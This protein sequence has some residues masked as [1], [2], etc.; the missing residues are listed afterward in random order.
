MPAKRRTTMP[1]QLKAAFLFDMGRAQKIAA[2]ADAATNALTA[3]GFEPESPIL[4]AVFESI[5]LALDMIADKYDIDRGAVSR[6]AFDN[7]FGAVGRECKHVDVPDGLLPITSPEDF[8][9]SE[10]NTPET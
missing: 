7:K 10:K 6:F 5:D 9:D 1:D 8:W 3:V 2:G 4:T